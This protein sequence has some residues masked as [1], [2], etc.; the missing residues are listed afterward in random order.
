MMEV[1]VATNLNI[2][3]YLK[4]FSLVVVEKGGNI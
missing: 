3:N 1:S 4:C 2:S